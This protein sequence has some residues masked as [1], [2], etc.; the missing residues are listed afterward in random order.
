MGDSDYQKGRGVGGTGNRTTATAGSNGLIV[1]VW[2][3]DECSVA[4]TCA[5]GGTC[6]NLWLI[7]FR[8]TCANGYAGY[9]CRTD[10][11]ECA[12]VPC[13]NGGTCVDG[14]DSWSCVCVAGFSG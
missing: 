4:G 2:D 14:V 12:S 6:T 13:R 1:A 11:N 3:I 10:T 5:N 7:G 8:C 9:T